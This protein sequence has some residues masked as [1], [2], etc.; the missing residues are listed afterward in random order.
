MTRA[1]PANEDRLLSE[2]WRE[3][4]DSFGG[5]DFA[6][7][8]AQRAALV[9]MEIYNRS[10]IEEREKENG[11]P[12]SEADL[13]AAA[14]IEM[15]LKATGIPVVCEE[16]VT[17][18]AT[19]APLFWLVDPLD[20]TKEFLAKNG[21]FTV[22]IALIAA[23]EPVC[24]VIGIPVTGEVYYAVKGERA[25]RRVGDRAAPI[26]NRRTQSSLIAAVSR[27]HGSDAGDSWLSGFG[28]ESRIQCGSAIKFCRVA[29]GKAD[30]YVRFGRTMEWDTAAGQCILEASGCRV[31]VADTGRR[32]T[33]GKD[34][35]DNPHFIA[36]RGD[37][38]VTEQRASQRVGNL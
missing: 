35:F 29:E 11:S 28:V 4:L 38:S 20:G 32:L 17:V 36:C 5:V 25:H 19:S 10:H 7:G 30:L 14:L 23:G 8:I 15:E 26:F 18:D 9:I 3:A 16:T 22:N 6:V 2:Q 37:L 21:E 12:V 27:S 34:G 1:N 24:G 13:A 33:Y 31:V